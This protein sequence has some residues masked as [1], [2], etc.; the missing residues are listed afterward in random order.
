MILLKRGSIGQEV[1]R[2]QA[3]LRGINDDSDV[4]INGVFDVTTE[5]ETIKFQTSKKLIADGIVGPKTFEMAQKFEYPEAYGD[6]NVANPHWPQNPGIKNLSFV[7]RRKLFGNFSYIAAPTAGNPEAIRI[8][9]GWASSNITTVT[10]PQLAGVS[11][12]S[13]MGAVQIHTKI[14]NQTVALFHA[15]DDA[16]LKD[17]ILTWGGSWVPRFIRGSRTSLSNHAW[18]TAFD[19][20]AQWNGLGAKPAVVDQ[21]GCVRE[22]V[23]IAVQ[24]GFYWGGWFPNRPDGM[25]F[26]AYKIL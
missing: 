16:G 14:A 1:E 21:K 6:D 20:N 9:D 5:I 19:I 11:G 25:H 7:D 4:V 15:W 17:R 26:E 8:T 18:G 3:F 2:W 22:L 24:F 12:A 13:R 10:I 23:E